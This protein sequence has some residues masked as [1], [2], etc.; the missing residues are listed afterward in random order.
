M[1]RVKATTALQGSGEG[2]VR[3]EGAGRR[4]GEGEDV[5]E[6]SFVERG[7]LDGE[8]G[9]GGKGDEHFVRG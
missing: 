4:G 5:Q 3:R 8:R 9:G 7:S 6:G 1:I 2:R